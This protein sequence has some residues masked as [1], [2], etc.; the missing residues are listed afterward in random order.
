[1]HV[2][3][4]LF[5]VC[6]FVVEEQITHG[7]L[8]WGF[9]V[10]HVYPVSSMI[11]RR[12]RDLKFRMRGPISPPSP[13]VIVDI[14]SASLDQV[15]RWPWRRDYTAYLIQQTF[16][17]GAKF[18]G[19]DM[20][21]SEPQE[22]VPEEL[23]NRLFE[24]NRGDWVKEFD[25]DGQLAAL[26]QP[27]QDRLVVGWGSEA[28]CRPAFHNQEECPVTHPRAIASLPQD[29]PKF[30]FDKIEFET[31]FHPNET[32][33]MSVPTVLTNTLLFESVLKHTG[34]VNA[35]RD[36]DG[37]VRGTSLVLFANGV[38]YPSFSLELAKLAMGKETKIR[39]DSHQQVEFLGWNDGTPLTQ[40][41]TGMYGVN[42]YGPEGR[43]PYVSALDVLSDEDTLRD[44]I[45]GKLTG[46][47]KKS[48][49]NGAIVLIGTSALAN[50]D[51]I[52][53]PFDNYIPGVE[54]HAT[55]ID[56]LMSGRGL[57]LDTPLRFWILLALLLFGGAIYSIAVHKMEG[58]SF[59][60]LTILM[61]ST[62][63][64]VDL[65]LFRRNWELNSGYLYLEFASILF[66]GIAA[67]H[68][69]EA[70][71][72][73][74]LKRALSKYVAPSVLEGIL[75]NPGELALGGQRR[76]MTVLF[77]D[78]RGFTS[79]AEDMDPQLLAQFLNDYLSLMSEAIFAHG[80][81]IDKFIGDAIM[82]FW[83]APAEQPDHAERACRAALEM[84]KTIANHR[85]HFLEKYQVDV[86]IGIGLSTGNMTVGNL[87]SEQTFD[88]TV[89]GDEVNLGA[90]LES[91]TKTFQV[92]I[93]ASEKTYAQAK[94]SISGI[95]VG[96]IQVKGKRF[97]VN[98]FLILDS[99]LPKETEKLF[100]QAMMLYQSEKWKE[101][102]FKFL[103][104]KTKFPAPG[105]CDAY[106]LLCEKGEKGHLNR[107]RDR[108]FK[109]NNVA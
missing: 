60:M 46:K 25:F 107:K 100:Q 94:G 16:A 71:K 9:A 13:V 17:A 63:F 39:M 51:R 2:G 26:M 105:L 76:E 62:F 10:D 32:S 74:F 29:F 22:G 15:G 50:Y 78:I 72:R 34:F 68:V 83:G 103:Q 56:N 89:V 98:P 54:V 31:P 99:P 27:Y 86:K 18:V 53:T 11:R 58:L 88:Y 8:Q 69:R 37:M 33:V 36:A 80:G 42:Y 90:R 64:V 93:L 66:T 108:V 85:S 57:K 55:I 75:K 87:G 43:F 48:L 67:K 30:A 7:S 70:H 65:Q 3:I 5:F 40:S 38:P 12:F 91:A 21:F 106:L 28:H 95:S 79:A 101:A 77:C 82:A 109:L 6:L 44:P 23:R 47:S 45:H 49:L 73:A 20:I 97:E 84:T 4:I 19:V 24:M 35:L 59:M 81:T 61:F 1:M 41:P 104:A 92:P 52:P 96:R 14:D 102:K